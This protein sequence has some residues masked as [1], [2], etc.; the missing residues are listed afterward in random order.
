LL[1]VNSAT[2]SQNAYLDLLKKTLTR[3]TFGET[4]D[5]YSPKRPIPVFAF[6]LAQ[7]VLS[8]KGLEIRRRVPF[9]AEMRSEGRDWPPDAETMIGLRRLDNIEFCIREIIKD[10]IPGDLIETGV[11]R[12]GGAIFMRAALSAYG[13]RGRVVWVA[14]S[15][16]GLPRPTLPQ[17]AGD[18]HYA[19]D[20]L[21]ISLEQVQDNFRKYQLLDDRVRFLKGWFKD[22]LATAPIKQLAVLRLDGDMYEST[23]DAL[24]PLYDK[25]SSGGFIIVDDYGLDGCRQAIT[26]FRRSHAITTATDQ[27]DSSGAIFWRK[28]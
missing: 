19:Y 4:H 2:F 17:D 13:D 6:R 16:E 28:E 25:V 27:I 24:N 10:S 12:G 23:M 20:H 21:A 22:T 14:D 15:F 26:D 9:S 18:V 5:T 11:W 7:K 3:F 8:S 1:P